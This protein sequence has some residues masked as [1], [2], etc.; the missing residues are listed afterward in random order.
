MNLK[1]YIENNPINNEKFEYFLSLGYGEKAAAVLAVLDY[2]NGM[3]AKFMKAFE[4]ENILDRV[5]NEIAESGAT[6]PEGVIN[7]YLNDHGLCFPMYEDRMMGSL[8]GASMPGMGMSGAMLGGMAFT[9]ANMASAQV[10]STGMAYSAPMNAVAGFTGIMYK[11]VMNQTPNPDLTATDS[12]E[13]IE[14]KDA[15]SVVVSPTSTFRMTTSAASVGILLNQIRNHRNIEMSQVRIEEL[16][17]YFDY[18]NGEWDKENRKKFRISTEIMDK[19]ENR[20]ILYI[21][22]EADDTPKQ[23]QNV[24]LLLDTSGSMSSQSDVTLETLATIVSKLKEND[25]LSMVTYSTEDHT[26]FTNHVIKGQSDREDLMGII[27]SIEIEGCTNGSAGI[28]TA[29]SLGEKTYKPDWSNQV[30]LITDGDLNFGINKLDGLRQLI[31]EKKK[32]GM[33]LSVIGTGL[34]NY[35]DDKLEVLSKYG[36]GTYCVVNELDDVKESVNRKYVSLTNIVAK[37]VKAQIEFNPKYVTKYRLLGYENRTLNHEDFKNDDVISEPYG[38]GGKGVALY[39]LYMG[40]ATETPE[41]NLK[42]RKMVLNDLDEIGTVS[43]RF[44]EPTDDV[45]SEISAVIPVEA[46][47]GDNV[48]KAYLIYCLSE[49]LRGSNK[50]DLSDFKYLADMLNDEKYRDFLKG[51]DE[52]FATMF[53][54]VKSTAQNPTVQ[55]S[56]SWTCTCGCMNTGKFC[57]D[58]GKPRG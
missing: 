37:D 10:M 16:L 33:F 38:S 9:Q 19:A 51:K 30:I 21:N 25:C 4:G 41:E 13:M 36:N 26:I 29:Y 5:Y 39:E 53:D 7:A 57:A 55:P 2:G 20:K 3:T 34:Y 11:A 32:T 1:K 14:E 48:K 49:K 46:K 23:Q 52:V 6:T 58:C 22:V 27:L 31:E 24:V 47:S 56:G 35:K 54:K 43:V 12:Y 28:E 42:Y 8:T 15:S 17:N 45:S 18:D 40:N 44:K 50:L